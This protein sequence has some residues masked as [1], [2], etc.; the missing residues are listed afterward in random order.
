[1]NTLK[2]RSFFGKMTLFRVRGNDNTVLSVLPAGNV[3]IIG[4]GDGISVL[5]SVSVL[6]LATGQT[7]LAAPM[8]HARTAHATATSESHIFAFGSMGDRL[9]TEA[10]FNS[11]IYDPQADT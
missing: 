11:E 9:T 7:S 8:L 1:M 2:V 5:N 4:G 10:T 6:S 3:F